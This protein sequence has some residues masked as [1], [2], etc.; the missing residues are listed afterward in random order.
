MDN[1]FIGV[2][3]GTSSARA[4]V[5]DEKGR[6]LG[7]AKKDITLWRAKGGIVE[8]ASD[9]IW[10]AICYCTKQAIKEA[11]IDPATVRGLGFDATCSLVVLDHKGAP[12]AV[13]PSNDPNRN[14]MVWMDHRAIEQA[15]RINA[16]GQD[17]LR[18]VGG[19]IS[20]E[21]ETP[22]L[23]WLKEN[24]P[25]T[26]AAARYFF[27]LAD[28][29]SWRAT[30]SEVRSICTLTC[31]WTYLAHEKRW[32]MNYFKAIGLEELAKNDFARIGSEVT[33]IA[34]PLGNG[35]SEA[36]A[37]ELGLVAGTPVGASLIDAHCGGI[38]TFACT[39]PKGETLAPETQMALVL[40]TSACALT[41]AKE[42][43][44]VDGV[45]GP[46]YG[47]MVPGYWLLEGGQSA[48]GAALDHLVTLHPAFGAMK[49]KAAEAGLALP[50]YLEKRATEKAG[51][52]EAVAN[53]ARN[54]HIVP[55]FLGN[56]APHA[57]PQ[58]TGVINGLTLDSSEDS[59]INLYVA[60]LCG[61]CYG[62]RQIIEAEKAKG[63]PLETL[64]VSGGAA[65]SPLLRRI[66]ADAS[67]MQVALP[68]T[69][70]PVLL[71]GAIIGAVAAGFYTDLQ[72]AA[73]NMSA[74]KDIC[75][76][77]KGEVARL[78][79]KKFLAFVTLQD[80]NRKIR[81]VMNGQ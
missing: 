63:L 58:A 2:D 45:W 67:G 3:V 5:F 39:G 59:L 76:P 79:D 23:L 36:A 10:D 26:F 1:H 48:Y 6:L 30:G 9:N 61:L 66:L 60:G 57:D 51:T 42:A 74:I 37:P 43:Q 75:T 69:V 56:R 15:N 38:G 28:F 11:A 46:Y 24:K 7:V 47:A 13:G 64:V 34:S 54:L 14:I 4:G 80:A 40:G 65:Q 44:F 19:K 81:K 73:G 55:E 68:E 72:T 53:M 21:M 33:E 70:E 77:N 27:D 52:L 20:P 25:E 41:L 31:K 8:Q 71:G 16:S 32:D 12:L 35:L 17:V 62:T 18:Y 29:L 50:V 22:K 49:E 78:H